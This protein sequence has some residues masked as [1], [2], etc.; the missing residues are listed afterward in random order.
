[1]QGKKTKIV[2]HS[3]CTSPKACRAFPVPS[4]VL[5]RLGELPADLCN[6]FWSRIILN[7]DSL[8]DYCTLTL[9]NKTINKMCKKREYDVQLRFCK[10]TNVIHEDGD[11]ITKY[12][13][14]EHLLQ[15]DIVE[16]NGTSYHVEYQI[17][18]KGYSNKYTTACVL[19]YH[20]KYKNIQEL[21]HIDDDVFIE[22]N[23]RNKELRELAEKNNCDWVLV[24]KNR[25]SKDKELAFLKFNI[26]R[27]EKEKNVF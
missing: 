26:M 12:H 23:D 22:K 21:K 3:R 14:G 13:S 6:M 24:S 5:G 25:K 15:T 2:K 19:Q 16:T 11:K 20:I 17:E 10:K 18:K 27:F 8:Q 1:M 4:T 7:V 9:L